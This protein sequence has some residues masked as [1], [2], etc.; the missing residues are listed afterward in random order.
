MVFL[1]TNTP[2]HFQDDSNSFSDIH[3]FVLI[4]LTVINLLNEYW[5]NVFIES[6]SISFMVALLLQVF[7]A[8]NNGSRASCRKLL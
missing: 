1:R 5:G 2:D 6:F 8:V 7:V 3:F 4:D